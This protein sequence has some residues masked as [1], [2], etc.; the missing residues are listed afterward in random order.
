MKYVTVLC[1]GMADMPSKTLDGKTP[2]EL[3]HKPVMDKLARFGEV[4]MVRTVPHGMPAGSDVANLTVLGYDTRECYTGRAPLEAANLGIDL[5]PSDIAFRCNL[6]TLSDGEFNDKK[7]LD[8]CAGDIHTDEAEKIIADIQSEFGG[9]KFDFYTGTAY[10]HCM[11]WHNGKSEFELTPPHDITGKAIA[12]HLPSDPNA[13]ALLDI[14][15][16]S[17]ELLRYHPVNLNRIKAGLRPANAVWLWGQGSRP[18][19]QNFNDRFK[20][21]GAVVSAVDLIKGIAKLTGMHVCEVEGATGYIDTNYEGKIAAAIEQ[22]K[23]GRD[24]VYIHIEAPDECGHRGQ[25]INKIRAIE[26]IDSRVLKPLIK[27]LDKM[28]EQYRVSILPDHPTP[29]SIRTH[30]DAP[31]PYLLYTNDTAASSGIDSFTEDS[32]HKTGRF[33]EQGHT[34]IQ[35][36][37]S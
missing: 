16:R 1:D 23:C 20:I 30:S 3:A 14:M 36:L 6:V 24:F 22:L 17:T 26:D 34:L 19:F 5:K 21:D 11:I 32:A 29:L 4:G 33:I 31:V 13:D 12:K 27:A 28:G 10:R 15:R 8:Y 2:M 18:K 35:K 37:F 9:G 7:M 25:A